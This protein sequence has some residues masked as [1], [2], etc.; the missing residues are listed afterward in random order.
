MRRCSIEALIGMIQ[1]TGHVTSYITGTSRAAAI[2]RSAVDSYTRPRFSNGA[3]GLPV[4]R[5]W[6]TTR[7]SRFGSDRARPA[8]RVRLTRG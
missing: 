2:D 6:T 1:K 5:A 8:F 4:M 3:N 7:F